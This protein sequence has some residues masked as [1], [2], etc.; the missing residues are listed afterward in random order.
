MTI[1]ELAQQ[2]LSF[3]LESIMA[4]SH[5]QVVVIPSLRDAAHVDAVF[6]QPPYHLAEDAC[7]KFEATKVHAKASE[8]VSSL[9]LSLF[10]L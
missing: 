5:T 6:P 9:P 7:K 10:C 3:A 8:R 1:D 2:W 4:T